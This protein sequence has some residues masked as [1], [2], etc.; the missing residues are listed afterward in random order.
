M[1]QR[2][3]CT[4]IQDIMPINMYAYALTHVM[5]MR[6]DKKKQA[7]SGASLEQQIQTLRAE[8]KKLSRC[9]S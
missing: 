8:A 3:L 2:T 1:H 5:A 4:C 9:V 6:S 7:A